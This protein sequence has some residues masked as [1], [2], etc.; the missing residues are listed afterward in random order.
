M[1]G[2]LAS[3]ANLDDQGFAAVV[4]DLERHQL[5]LDSL[6]NTGDSSS[7]ENNSIS[8]S[9]IPDGFSIVTITICVDGVAKS[10]DVIARGPY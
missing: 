6:V 10:L 3:N 1:A 7:N 2:I 5:I 8:S 4:R 9:G